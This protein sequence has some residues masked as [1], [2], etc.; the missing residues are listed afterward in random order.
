MTSVAPH[1]LKKSDTVAFVGIFVASF[2]L[3]LAI[4]LFAQLLRW[5]WRAWLPGAE[6]EKSL[7]HGVKSA[8]YTFMSNLT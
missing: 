7:I 3:F 2:V 4:A 1:D 8:V 5:E 6:G